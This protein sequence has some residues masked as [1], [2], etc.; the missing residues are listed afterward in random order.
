MVPV[1]PVLRQSGV[2]SL[3]TASPATAASELLRNRVFEMFTVIPMV[4]HSFV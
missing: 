4:T 3:H 1:S 2:S